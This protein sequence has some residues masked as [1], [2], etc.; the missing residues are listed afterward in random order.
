MESPA[1]VQKA[2]ERNIHRLYNLPEDTEIH[3][4]KY[5]ENYTFQVKSDSENIKR[6]LRVNRPSYHTDEELSGELL[7]MREI[8]QDTDLCLPDVFCGNNNE[9]LQEFESDDTRYTC[10]MFSFLEGKTIGKLSGDE[11]NA[12]LIN[13]GKILASLHLQ[14]QNR[15]RAYEIKRFSWDISN[16]LGKASIWGDWHNYYELDEMTCNI[17]E[18]V[19]NIMKK[20][21]SE[22]G[23]SNDKFGMIHADLHRSN[24]IVKDGRPQIFDFDDCGYG[25]YL[26]DIG[27]SLVEFSNPKKLV[28]FIIEGY[29]SVKPLSDE[30]KKEIDTFVLLRRIVRMAWLSSHNDSDTAKMVENGYF[31]NTV[32]MAESYILNNKE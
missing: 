19:T 29:E 1:N 2:L 22:Y 32:N 8:S 9:L 31:T 27:C 13:M 16:L 6:V 12:Q 21:L 18:Q 17:F 20:R 4:L 26:Y 10:C 11:L 23:Y 14:W 25:W 24:I 30:E 7:W 28:P 5:S 3:L 15:K